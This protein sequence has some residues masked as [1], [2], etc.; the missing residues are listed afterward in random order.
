M[1]EHTPG[2]W[3]HSPR[4][5]CGPAGDWG[6][7][8]ADGGGQICYVG[9]PYPRGDNHPYENM[10]LIAAAPDLLSAIKVARA[11]IE[12]WVSEHGCCKGSE[13]EALAVID[14]AINK[15]ETR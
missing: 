2:P 14:A 15:A 4:E 5:D 12:W 3:E 7:W 6:V 1:A 11:N 10:V 9:D 8:Q 13:K